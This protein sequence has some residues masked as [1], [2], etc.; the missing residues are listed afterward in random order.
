MDKDSAQQKASSPVGIASLIGVAIVFVS[1]ELLRVAIG[2]NK[3]GLRV[4][5][6]LGFI[7]DIL[8]VGVVLLVSYGGWPAVAIEASGRLL[9][10]GSWWRVLVCCIGAAMHGIF[11][12][13]RGFQEVSALRILEGIITYEVIY[14]GA[15]LLAYVIALLI[16]FVSGRK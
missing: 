6:S 13:Y 3:N 8:D 2:W 7:K 5:M 15:L 11:S 16:W 9:N 12:T 4:P 1:I 14:G 10:V